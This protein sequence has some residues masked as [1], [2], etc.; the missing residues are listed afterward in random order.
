MKHFSLGESTA[1]VAVFLAFSCSESPETEGMHEGNSGKDQLHDG[2][3]FKAA[4]NDVGLVVNGPDTF[5]QVPWSENY[6]IP[7]ESVP[8][9][10]DH[11]LSTPNPILDEMD[12]YADFV[13]N[14]PLDISVYNNMNSEWYALY[15]YNFYNRSDQSVH[16]DCTVVIFRGPN[17]SNMHHSYW[18][19]AGHGHPQ[20]DYVEVQ[21][22]GTQDSYYIARLVFHDVPES[23]RTL[24]PG[25]SFEYQIGVPTNPWD[26]PPHITTEASKYTVRVI[27]DLSGNKNED[28]VT[29]YGTKRFRN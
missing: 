27:A 25:E 4:S 29:K 26:S 12:L 23:Q 17:G 3:Q 24:Y 5:T 10:G 21:I 11:T 7:G 19:S 2:A 15:Q 14:I 1:L 28:L 22:P 6:V 9:P 18:N 16:L 8:I 20:Q 13:S